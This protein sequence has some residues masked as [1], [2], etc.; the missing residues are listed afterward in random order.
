MRRDDD[1]IRVSSGVK[2]QLRFRGVNLEHVNLCEA[3]LG[4]LSSASESHDT[5]V[6]PPDSDIHWMSFESTR[7]IEFF[8][9]G[10]SSS[11]GSSAGN[12]TASNVSSPTSQKDS[13]ISTFSDQSSSN[14]SQQAMKVAFSLKKFS[15]IKKIDKTLPPAKKITFVLSVRFA[16]WPGEARVFFKFSTRSKAES[17]KEW[18]LEKVLDSE[19]HPNLIQ[20]IEPQGGGMVSS[21]MSTSS[22][23]SAHTLNTHFMHDNGSLSNGMNSSTATHQMSHFGGSNTKNGMMSNLTPHSMSMDDGV[24]PQQ[25][26]H[27]GNGFHPNFMSSTNSSTMMSSQNGSYYLAQQQA[28]QFYFSNPGLFGMTPQQQQQQQPN[29]LGLGVPFAN[30]AQGGIDGGHPLLMQNPQQQQQQMH[31]MTALQQDQ[32]KMQQQQQPKA[33]SQGSHNPVRAQKSGTESRKRSR[34]TFSPSA[35]DGLL[36]RSAKKKS[37]ENQLDSLSREE[38]P[39]NKVHPVSGVGRFYSLKAP[40]FIYFGSAAGRVECI[41]PNEISLLVPSHEPTPKP[42]NVTVQNADRVPI[43]SFAQYRFLEEQKDD[44]SSD[45]N[46]IT[47]VHQ[48]RQSDFEDNL[49]F[50]DFDLDL[51]ME[52]IFGSA[53]IDGNLG[54]VDSLG[55]SLLHRAASEGHSRLVLRLLIEGYNPLHQ[56][57][58]GRTAFHVASARGS[59]DCA[60]IL[61]SFAGIDLYFVEDAYSMNGIDL[62]MS[63]NQRKLIECLQQWALNRNAQMK[64]FDDVEQFCNEYAELKDKTPW[65]YNRSSELI[66]PQTRAPTQQQ[67]PEDDRMRT[68]ERQNQQLR[69]QL[70]MSEKKTVFMEMRMKHRFIS[71]LRTESEERRTSRDLEASTPEVVS[72]EEFAPL[73]E[74]EMELLA[75]AQPEPEPENPS[76]EEQ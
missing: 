52:S 40:V 61:L 23:G 1:N 42:V 66:V 26:S 9:V 68:L 45:I 51:P 57:N 48:N 29:S 6:P 53:Q 74:M 14:G 18:K 30:N 17:S 43:T 25:H 69:E 60:K 20:L 73:P 46:S 71:R 62:A 27:A 2:Y 65:N 47:N 38:G 49:F 13:P 7:P 33:F 11:F 15:Q 12:G 70:E 34:E 24:D 37:L 67:Q 8:E 32:R 63:C 76:P 16:S 58:I 22:A 54:G 59:T 50:R 10:H 72:E 75:N 31:D 56:D 55:Q 36:Q 5:G 4:R 35:V 3:R 44:D 41:T 64:Y 21:P 19:Q 39:A 28:R